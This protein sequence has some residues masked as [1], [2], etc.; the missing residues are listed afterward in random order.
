MMDS[1]W[2]K[3]LS[4]SNKVTEPFIH[5][6]VLKFVDFTTYPSHHLRTNV[7]NIRTT[8]TA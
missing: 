1:V 2:E 6:L 3:N 5:A 4:P 7:E 8:V